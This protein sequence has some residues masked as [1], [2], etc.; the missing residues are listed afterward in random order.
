[1]FICLL[2]FQLRGRK[3]VTTAIIAGVTAVALA[4]VVPGNSYIVLATVFAATVGIFIDK[5]RRTG[6]PEAG[7]E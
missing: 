7:A 2:V 4:L 6:R 1:M 5:R 3:Y